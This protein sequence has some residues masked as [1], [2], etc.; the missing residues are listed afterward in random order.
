M[1][2][3]EENVEL[4]GVSAEVCEDALP[5]EEGSASLEIHDDVTGVV[6]NVSKESNGEVIKRAANRIA[7]VFS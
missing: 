2:R 1:E 7:S 4:N 6:G 3:I 5:E